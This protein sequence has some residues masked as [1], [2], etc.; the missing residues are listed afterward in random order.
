MNPVI[1]NH[2]FQKKIIFY[3]LVT[4]F[5]EYSEMVESAKNAGFNRDD[6]D[7]FY[8]D[9]KNSNDFD[10]YSGINHV[11]RDAKSEYI[12]FCHQDILF[13]Y[14]GYEK[15][16]ECIDELNSI[17]PKWA[18]A[19][20]AGKTKDGKSRRK[21]SDPHGVNQTFGPFPSQVISIDENFIVINNKYNLSC[22][23]QMSGFHLYGIDICNNAIY[24]GLNCYVID[25][26]L[27]HKSKGDI[28]KSFF[29][30]RKRFINVQYLRLQQKFYS[31]TCTNFYVSSIKW[32]NFILNKKYIMKVYSYLRK[33]MN[34]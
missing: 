14:D 15:L 25:F 11:L 4:R 20:N 8:F 23:N 19:G 33:I 24:L 30:S 18:I 2:S 1:K 13:N 32:I 26:H 6:V 27:T 34:K 17:D 16:I 21:I 9:N 28:N 10:G 3:T 5:D 22:S 7:F 29:D 31:T 12:I